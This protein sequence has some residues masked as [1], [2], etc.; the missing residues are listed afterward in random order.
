MFVF[1]HYLESDF[2]TICLFIEGIQDHERVSVPELKPGPEIAVDYASDVVRRVTEN[3]GVILLVWQD[4]RP[5]AF[6]SSWVDIDADLLLEEEARAHAYVSDIYVS[7][8]ARR[9]GIAS[10]LLRR[11]ENEMLAR[12]CRRMR[13]CTKA[14]NRQALE[15]YLSSGYN[16]YEITLSK[17]LD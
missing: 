9:Q 15:C 4:D 7:E 17:M 5:V 12:G 2:D 16:P 6:A 8:S 13:I 3:D 14:S 10:E 1:A 11:L